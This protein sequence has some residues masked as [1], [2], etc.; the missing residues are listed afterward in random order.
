MQDEE[1]AAVCKEVKDELDKKAFKNQQVQQ[2]EPGLRTVIELHRI[3]ENPEDFKIASTNI[4]TKLKV[5]E[6]NRKDKKSF[7]FDGKKG[8][9]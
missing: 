3:T 9:K 6:K 5:L 4:G 2:V 1:F 8:R 7:G